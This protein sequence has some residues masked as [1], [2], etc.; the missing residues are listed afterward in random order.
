VIPFIGLVEAT[1]VWAFRRT[2]LPMQRIREALQ[3]WRTRMKVATRNG[4]PVANGF[5]TAMNAHSGG[6]GVRLRR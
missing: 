2:N 1:V 3:Y 4:P 6:V 5:F